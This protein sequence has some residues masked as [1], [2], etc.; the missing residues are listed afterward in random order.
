MNESR[1]FVG[2]FPL[3]YRPSGPTDSRSETSYLARRPDFRLGDAEIR[4]ALRTIVGPAGS[5]KSEPRVMQVLVALAEADG[6]VLTREDLIRSCWKGQIVGDDAINRAIGELRKVARK[7]AA[8]FEVETIPRVGYRLVQPAKESADSAGQVEVPSTASRRYVMGGSLA[9]AAGGIGYFALANRSPDPAD[10]LIA[11][12]R[13]ATLAGTPDAERKAIELLEQAVT[14]SPGNATA[15]GLLALTR[16][17]A[18]EHGLGEP[19]S[20]MSAIAEPATRALQIDRSNAD[21]K[22]ALALAVPYYGSW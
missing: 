13:A 18:D 6:A 3:G 17:R 11:E 7:T 1:S 15:W 21:A 14:R 2:S 10:G 22:A 19:T 5:A 20:P 16:A 12:S 4:P 9:L 8:G